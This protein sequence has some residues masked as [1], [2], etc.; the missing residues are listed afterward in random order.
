MNPAPQRLY[1]AIVEDRIVHPDDER[2]NRHVA[3]PSPVT[4]AGG[5]A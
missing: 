4:G 5:G 1:D 2:L 3:A